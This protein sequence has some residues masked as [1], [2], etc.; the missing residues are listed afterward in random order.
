MLEKQLKNCTIIAPTTGF[1]LSKKAE[2]GGYVNPLALAPPVT[3]AKSPTW[4]IWK[5]KSMFRSRDVP[6][7]FPN[8]VCTVMPEAY[9]R[10]DAFLKI[11]PHGYEA[12]VSRIMPTANRAK[13]AIPVRVTVVIPKGEAGNYLR[14]D[15]GVIVSFL[16]K[17]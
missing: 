14:P 6:R 5:S 4:A 8:Q 1:I 15:M 3:C 2:L 13:G 12:R 9:Q 10:D 11:H 17:K 16:N 7:V